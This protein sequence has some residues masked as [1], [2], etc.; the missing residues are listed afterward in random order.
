[1]KHKST[2]LLISSFIICAC[3]KPIPSQNEFVLGTLCT[4]TL[5]EKGRSALYQRIFSRLREIEDTMSANRADTDVD[6]INQM[7]AI[8]PVPVG[9][10]LFTVIET[11]LHYAQLSE[12]AFDPTV[13]P[14]VKL[15]NIGFD[16]ARIPESG[17]IASVLPLINWRNV[18]LDQQHKTV[19]LTAPGM[20]LD[21]GGIAKGYAAD[22][23]VRIIRSLGIPRAI[24]N[25]GGNVYTYGIKKD[26][27]PWQVG[28]QDPLDNRDS[29]LGFM[30]IFNQTLVTS[31]V[32]ERYFVQDEKQYH[33]IL[34]TKTGYPAETGLLSVTVVADR[35]ID[36]DA[37]ST[38]IFAL[39]YE[40]GL[41]LL[42]NL[43]N[44]QAI[45]VFKDGTI[46]G[47][48]Q[49]LKN[50]TLTNTERFTL[51]KD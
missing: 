42:E 25:L 17:E 11:A 51:I 35:S 39:G 44:V 5:Y 36:A 31:G 38:G 41:A 21:L 14:L 37:L 16:N 23:A 48:P 20:Q 34:S 49:A 46:H 26:K 50:F 12:G 47:T 45:F 19:F 40:H 9:E 24:V 2:L 32:Y 15:W 28:I 27:S 3:A 30:T 1:M 6:R 13:G 4:V 7:A 33:H 8:A 10:D 18:I 43:G 22:E 29:S